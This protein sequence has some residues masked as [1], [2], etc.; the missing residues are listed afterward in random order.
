[1]S[2]H[3]IEQNFKKFDLNKK[4]KKYLKE[5]IQ[6]TGFKVEKKLWCGIILGDKNKT[7]SIIFSGRYKNKK[8]VLKIQHLKL[9]IEENDILKKLKENNKSKLIATQKVFSH[10]NWDT[11]RGYG[12]LITELIDYPKIYSSGMVTKKQIQEFCKIYQE[13]KTKI[14]TNPGW[15]KKDKYEADTVTFNLNRVNSWVKICK[16][17]GKLKPEFYEPKVK[18]YKKIIK[19]FCKDQPME[20]LHGHISPHDIIK[21]NN[22]K[23]YLTSNI[24]WSYRPKWYDLAINLWVNF[25]SIG[26]ETNFE[27]LIKYTKEWFRFYQEMPVAKKDKNFELWL[28]INLLERAMGSILIDFGSREYKNKKQAIYSFEMWNLVF[29]KLTRSFSEKLQLKNINS[30]SSDAKEIAKISVS[31]GAMQ[32]ISELTRLISLLKK[33]DLK[34]IV[35]IGTARGGSLHAWCKI[36]NSNAMLI[37]IDLP[38]GRFGGGYSKNDIKKFKTYKKINQKLH[39]LRMDSH[40][41]TTKQKLEKILNNQKI[42]F[43][44]IDGDHTYQG[45]KKDWELYNSLVNKGGIIAFHDI[46][47]TPREPGCQVDKLWKRIKNKNKIK[48]IIDHKS[49]YHIYDQWGGIGIIYK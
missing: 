27:E 12:Y 30:Q 21:V 28:R 20:F 16:S 23:Y 5:I 11:K 8:A 45:V 17:T 29:D 4:W 38:K 44:M 47:E 24:F 15:F 31:K 13:Y 43:L 37:S 32:K 36:A 14:K 46:V 2:N 22:K 7:G 42:D 6:E 1:M 10:K 35:E 9:S 33:R 39:F 41:K 25:N 18:I 26:S 48:E 19:N 49:N 34:T 40:K 3:I